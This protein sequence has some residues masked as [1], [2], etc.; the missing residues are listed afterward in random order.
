MFTDLALFIIKTERDI[1]RS[2][3]NKRIRYRQADKQ[4]AKVI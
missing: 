4:K 1:V 2:L 3:R